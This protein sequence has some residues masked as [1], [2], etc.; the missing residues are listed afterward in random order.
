MDLWATLSFF[1]FGKFFGS[2]HTLGFSKMHTDSFITR[3]FYLQRQIQIALRSVL[4]YGSIL[5][6]F[7]YMHQQF[8]YRCGKKGTLSWFNIDDFHSIP[9]Y[10]FTTGV[11]W[12]RTVESELR[13]TFGSGVRQTP[14]M[15]LHSKLFLL[16]P[17]PH[18]IL[19]E[20]NQIL[21]WGHNS[22]GVT[23][24]GVKVESA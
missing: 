1:L 8:Q 23:K 3:N 5:E 4:V 24:A 14:L 15:L 13:Q 12:V 10:S 7:L 22:P 16:S 11:G 2:G 18:P 21:C 17:A 20:V 9:Y 19:G 6:A